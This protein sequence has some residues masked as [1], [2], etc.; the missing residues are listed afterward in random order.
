MGYLLEHKLILTRFRV[1]EVLISLILILMLFSTFTP[2]I[3]VETSNDEI[4]R[5]SQ[6]RASEPEWPMFGKDEQHTGLGNPVTKGIYKGA[7][8]WDNWPDIYGNGI[9]SWGVTIGDFA[10]NIAGTYTL[11]VKHVVYADHGIVYIIDGED[12]THMWELDADAID[13]NANGNV[14]YTTPTI[15]YLNNNELLDIVFGTDDGMIYIYEPKITYDAQTGYSWNANNIN[16]EIWWSYTTNG[17]FNHTS[18]VL[19]D[20]NSDT[21]QDVVFCSESNIIALDV[22]NKKLLWTQTINSDLISPPAVYEDVGENRIVVTGFRNSDFNFSIYM[23]SSS[24]VT[25]NVI[26]IEL[27][28]LLYL[29]EILPAPVV[30]EL[31]GN[32]NNGVELVILTPFEENVNGKVH[33]IDVDGTELWVTPSGAISGQFDASPAIADLDGDSNLEIIVSS[34][35][36]IGIPPTNY[37]QS[38]VYAISGKNG[39][40]LWHRAKDTITSISFDIFD[41]RQIAS[42]VIG[43][44]NTDED[45]ILD[46][47]VATTPTIFALDGKNGTELWEYVLEEDNRILWSSPAIGDIDNDGFLDIVIEGLAL[48]HEIIDLTL[49]P[50][51]ISFTLDPI[52]ENEPVSIEAIVH[53]IGDAAASNVLVSFFD[54]NVLID[55]LTKPEIPGRDSRQARL[56]WTPTEP[57]QHIIKVVLDPLGEIEEIEENNN[58]AEK[59]VSVLDAFPDFVVD[60]LRFYRA[61]GL[62]V[63]NVDKHLIEGEESTITAIGRNIGSD[64]AENVKVAFYDGATQIGTKQTIDYIDLDGTINVSIKWVGTINP[65]DH[66]LKVKVDPDKN[67][68]E[69]NESNNERS[70]LMTIKSKTVPPAT[71][72]IV[73]GNVYQPDAV[74]L[75]ISAQVNIT[76]LRTNEDLFTTT[77][78][79]GYFSHDL[80]RLQSGYYEGEKIQVFVIDADDLNETTVDFI[81]Y[82]EDERWK[83]DIILEKLPKYAF[84]IT[85]EDD[86]HSVNPGDS[87][88]YTVTV[89]NRGNTDNSINLSLSKVIDISTGLEA[90]GWSAQLNDYYVEDLPPG[91][92]NSGIILTVKPPSNL[93]DV[94]A[95]QQVRVIVTGI[96]VYD[97]AMQDSATTTTTLSEYHELIMTTAN[98]YRQLNPAISVAANFTLELSNQG[99][100]DDTVAI[101]VQ[102]LPVGWSANYPSEV[103]V[104]IGKTVDFGV[105]ITVDQFSAAKM[106]TVNVN[107]TS[108]DG[109]TSRTQNLRIEIVRPDILISSIEINPSVPRIGENIVITAIIQNNGTVSASNISVAFREI[110]TGSILKGDTISDLTPQDL[111]YV[112]SDITPDSEGEYNIEVRVD[113][114]NDIIEANE[115]NNIAYKTFKLFPDLVIKEDGISFSNDFPPERTKLTIYVTIENIGSVDVDSNFY[116]E[117]YNG[118]PNFIEEGGTGVAVASLEVTKS[119]EL[120]REFT[121]ELTWKVIKPQG[122]DSGTESVVSVYVVLDAGDDI[123]EL[124]EDNNFDTKELSIKN[125]LDIAEEDGDLAVIVGIGVVIFIIIM[126][127]LFV[128]PTPAKKKGLLNKVLP[129]RS[130]KKPSKPKKGA[131]KQAEESKEKKVKPISKD[132]LEPSSKLRVVEIEGD[133]DEKVALKPKSVEV[134]EIV[135]VEEEEEVEV[136][137]IIEVEPMGDEEEYDD[138]LKPKR[139]KGEV[140]YSS[141]GLIGLR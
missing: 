38:H 119:I 81:A 102:G 42:P 26:P 75:A 101:D 67:F 13:G 15:G 21:N 23:Y 97:P 108:K 64:D 29:P 70:K 20:L 115:A 77:D 124:D 54:D 84:T 10:K 63:D 141:L 69:E 8:K 32:T 89:T 5:G 57:G 98:N 88:E 14:V 82:S 31:D 104:A 44:V 33:L 46:V 62:E 25:L 127:Y 16:T 51:D 52:T 129:P 36:M 79:T 27:G 48:S 60:E 55:N 86:A 121:F 113:V 116:I 92:S 100:V 72:F 95:N 110:N 40:I 126:V 6:P 103:A 140:D 37:I 73:E 96:S 111:I 17:T 59:I 93:S 43:D 138:E 47:I 35:E 39:T 137:E 49:S 28:I 56:D 2:I 134:S 120:G 85:I 125:K 80:K 130:D 87:T 45:G 58:H 9:D 112:T 91:G 131:K 41:E 139:A 123:T 114:N 136:E 117:L 135:E 30:G 7:E 83:E 128:I 18:P 65:A 122:S 34:W 4:A 105:D 50:S 90:K 132:R 68:Q 109:I 12:G 66:T 1:K 78:S 19:T 99:N 11:N 22:Y 106:Y 107:A 24:G 133:S 53:N 3:A 74:T 71:S 76:N 94:S 61:D 118:K